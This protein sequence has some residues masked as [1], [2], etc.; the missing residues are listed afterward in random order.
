MGVL[1]GV[2]GVATAATI[3]TPVGPPLLIASFLFGGSAT[4]VQMSTEFAITTVTLI[5]W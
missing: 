2:L 4:A 5:D 1:S 3:L